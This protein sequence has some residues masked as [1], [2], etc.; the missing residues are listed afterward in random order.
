MIGHSLMLAMVQ[1]LT[2][3]LVRM[4]MQHLSQQLRSLDRA[5]GHHQ[6][7]IVELQ[8]Q[9][10]KEQVRPLSQNEGVQSSRHLQQTFH[11]TP[12]SSGL[13]M[14]CNREAVAWNSNIY[15]TPLKPQPAT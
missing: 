11:R 8:S 3:H 7:E 6:A 12:G 4:Q 2:S 13:T 14:P 10:Q 9:L 1:T 15:L 5:C